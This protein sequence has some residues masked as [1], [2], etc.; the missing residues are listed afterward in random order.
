MFFIAVFIIA[1]LSLLVF[2]IVTL[3]KDDH[4]GLLLV[5]LP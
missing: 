2:G 4:S 5:S 3:G 1:G